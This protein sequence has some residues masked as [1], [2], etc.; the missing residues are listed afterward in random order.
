MKTPKTM[1]IPACQAASVCSACPDENFSWG[2]GLKISLEN[3][4]DCGRTEC[5]SLLQFPL[6][7][8][9]R[10]AHLVKAALVISPIK[11]NLKAICA[12]KNLSCFDR[13]EVDWHS[14]PKTE[15]S[16]FAMSR[17]EK[18]NISLNLLPALRQ[19]GN[20]LGVTL[21]AETPGYLIIK[22][23]PF[24]HICYGEKPDDEDKVII[25]N[26]FS[27]RNFSFE[28]S[29]QPVRFSPVYEASSATLLTFFVKNTGAY[30][31]AFN[32]QISPDGEQFAD[33][34]QAYTVEPGE[35]K[36]F[37]PYIFGR[38]MRV[39]I[40]APEAGIPT[41]AD[42][43]AQAQTGNYLLKKLD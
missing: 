21:A 31:F 26:I 39:K 7:A 40:A 1:I 6:S 29:I 30:P 14:R 4:Y 11:G 12:F 38:Y 36:A 3:F 35:L 28:R 18:D 15:R 17:V 33:D 5:R 43:W 42:I 16:P 32:I 24:L 8:I 20:I 10:D 19:R 25:E 9:P 22:K 34:G 23:A 2:A 13:R 37:A 41:S 27:D